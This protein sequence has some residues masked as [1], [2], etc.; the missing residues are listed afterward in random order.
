M[1]PTTQ[2]LLSA[3]VGNRPMVLV[4]DTTLSSG[5]TVTV[6][7]R[8]AGELLVDWGDGN[9][10]SVPY[11]LSL[12]SVTHTYASDG[13]YA[14]KLYG[15]MSAFGGNQGVR[16]GYDKLIRCE[17]FG[18][19]GLVDL[20]SGFSQATNL[21]EMPTVLPPTVTEID[22]C[23]LFLSS[24][25]AP[26]IG[27]WDTSNIINMDQLFNGAN[28]FDQDISGWDVSNVTNMRG[29]FLNAASFNQD[30]SSWDVGNVT[31]MD[32]MFQVAQSFNQDLS[33]WVTGLTS[34]PSNFS[35]DANIVFANNANGLKPYLSDGVTQINT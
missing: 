2:R 7:L 28:S 5:T 35:T 15:Y 11:S 16:T 8:G 29:M 4:F 22:S 14:V 19:L 27:S 32:N 3:S 9:T 17:S 31:N 30:I 21:S 26:E 10:S 13:T 18:D 12:S 20:F 23:F 33:S 34:Q 25:N 6:P 1:D 24:F